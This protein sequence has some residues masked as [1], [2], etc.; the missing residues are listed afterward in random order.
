MFSCLV[1]WF[2]VTALIEICDVTQPQDQATTATTATTSS[3]APPVS[4]TSTNSNTCVK[5]FPMLKLK[6]P[7]LTSTLQP[8]RKKIVSAQGKDKKADAHKFNPVKQRKILEY[9]S[10]QQDG[11][12]GDRSSRRQGM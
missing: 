12:I 7:T 4:K 10:T 6:P 11:P 5:G 3:M 9:V 2:K 1:Y 8:R